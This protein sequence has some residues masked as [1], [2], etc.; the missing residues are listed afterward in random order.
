[1]SLRRLRLGELVVLAGAACVI[2]ALLRSWYQGPVGRLDAWDTFGPAVVL[3]LA[4][5]SAALA[6]VV[7]ALGERSPALPVSMA[8]WCVAL[9]LA[10]TIASIVRVIERPQHSTELCAGAWLALAGTV[11]ITVGAWLAL[12][13]ERTSLYGPAQPTPRPRP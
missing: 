3:V 12:R 4:A 13:D 2:I 11:L 1:V 7:S 5:L 6:T 10:G 8:V 9:G